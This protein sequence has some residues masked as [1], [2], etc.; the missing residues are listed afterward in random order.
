MSWHFSQALVAASLEENSLVGKQL[1]Q[2]NGNLTPS[3]FLSNDRM[4][5]FSRLSRSGM[6]FVPLTENLGTEL[7][8]LY[9]GGFR[10]KTLVQQGKGQ[11]LKGIGVPC[12]SKCYESSEKLNQSSSSL[13]TPTTYVLKDLQPSFKGLPKQGIMLSGV[14]YP[15]KTVEPITNESEYGFS[16]ATPT[17]QANQL[18]PSMQKHKSC[19]NL[20]EFIRKKYPTPTCHN[21]KEGGYPAEGNRNT[22]TLGWELGGKPHPIFTEWMMR[23]PLGWT[24]LKPLATDKFQLWQQQ[25]LFS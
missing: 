4:K 16:L 6:T 14:C 8:T 5:A 3:A 7:L 1:Q 21:A 25:H 15:L 19:S 9:L 12:G 23:W 10:A 13:K 17:C 2:L 22:P 11:D 20:T 18:A 24:D